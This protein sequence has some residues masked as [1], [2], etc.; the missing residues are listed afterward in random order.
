MN[1]QA[2]WR[3]DDELHESPR[4][5]VRFFERIASP[6]RRRCDRAQLREEILHRPLVFRGRCGTFL[7]KAEDAHESDFSPQTRDQPG[8]VEKVAWIAPFAARGMHWARLHCIF[9][10]ASPKNAIRSESRYKIH[11]MALVNACG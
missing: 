1:G 2:A 6:V 3:I 5:A 11:S 10:R 9:Q 7:E 4:A 8:A